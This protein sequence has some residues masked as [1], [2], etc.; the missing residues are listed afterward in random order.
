MTTINT[1]KRP[2]LIWMAP[3]YHS[4][5]SRSLLIKR[6]VLSL[7][8]TKKYTK[9]RRIISPPIPS[10]VKYAASSIPSISQDE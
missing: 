8:V 9:E 2:F 7:K 10:A 3:N 6:E 4:S 5:L 1:I